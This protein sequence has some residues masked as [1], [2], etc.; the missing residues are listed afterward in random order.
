MNLRTEAINIIAEMPEIYIFKALELLEKFKQE[1]EGKSKPHQ[2]VIRKE[3][4][5]AAQIQAAI[6]AI[7]GALP[8]TDITLEDLRAERLRKYESLA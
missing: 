1:Y 3:K 5:N 6:E 4:A 8:S 2:K 7:S